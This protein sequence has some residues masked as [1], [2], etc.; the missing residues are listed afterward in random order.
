MRADETDGKR[1]R[2]ISEN[3]GRNYMSFFFLSL[4]CS[5]F[6]PIL[7]CFT[8]KE[9]F[10]WK[11]KKFTA[12]LVINSRISFR[13][14]TFPLL[15]VL[16]LLSS[17]G[18]SCA[19]PNR[20][21]N[22]SP[23]RLCVQNTLYFLSFFVLRV[24]NSTVLLTCYA[25]NK[26]YRAELSYESLWEKYLINGRI[27]SQSQ[28]FAR[29]WVD[30]SL[31]LSWACVYGTALEHF[32]DHFRWCFASAVSCLGFVFARKTK[33]YNN[34]NIIVD[35]MCQTWDSRFFAGSIAVCWCHIIFLHSVSVRCVSAR[36]DVSRVIG[37]FNLVNV[38][39]TRSEK[40]A[41]GRE[42][43]S[44]KKSSLPQN[45]FHSC[46]H[47]SATQH[48]DRSRTCVLRSS[49]KGEQGDD[50]KRIRIIIKWL[51]RIYTTHIAFRNWRAS[52]GGGKFS[53]LKWKLFHSPASTNNS[54]HRY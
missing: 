30:V 11:K 16:V 36:D 31:S 50:T 32:Y 43:K 53:G 18:P 22:F 13:W 19:F 51:K 28:L 12:R 44:E 42:G 46:L 24:N 14:E 1:R 37:L 48:T 3:S 35:V 33:S 25:P 23:S 40:R 9:I 27:L 39:L 47:H 15:F 5:V 54:T 41:G 6:A 29:V 20:T 17:V 7:V 2:E 4:F 34:S 21:W 45:S 38:K 26:L 52:V 10:I 49:K 8:A